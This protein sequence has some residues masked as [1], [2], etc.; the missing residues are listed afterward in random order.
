MAS[1]YVVGS[2]AQYGAKKRKASAPSRGF[3][4]A[5]SRNLYYMK[6]PRGPAPMTV[7]SFDKFFNKAMIKRNIAVPEQKWKE[8]E[9][10]GTISATQGL[11]LLNGLALGDS[12]GTRTG[13]KVVVT[14]VEMI[15]NLILS[16]TAAAGYDAGKIAL[17]VDKQANGA[18]PI[19]SAG[20]GTSTIAPYTNNA[21]GPPLIKNAIYDDQFYIVK[22][23][24]YCLDG[25]YGIVGT[26]QQRD[27]ATLKC[28]MP[29]RRVVNYNLLNNGTVTDIVTNAIYLGYIGSQAAGAT[30]TSF[31]YILRVWYTDA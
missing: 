8:I 3:A 6:G 9:S 2:N 11:V 1:T 16:A 12:Q 28:N 15:A 4:S 13:T 14:K 21:G 19:F 23:W 22:D 26:S 27:C 31:S 17:F 30:A 5:L 7:Q 20:G 24:D 18:S 29:L 10:A 25:N